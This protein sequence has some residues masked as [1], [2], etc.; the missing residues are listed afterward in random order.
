VLANALAVGAYFG[1]KTSFFA[2]AYGGT[3]WHNG[4]MRHFASMVGLGWWNAAIDTALTG[5]EHSCGWTFRLRDLSR[6][7]VPILALRADEFDRAYLRM[8]YVRSVIIRS[9]TDG[10]VPVFG[11]GE[12]R[13]EIRDEVEDERLAAGSDW[14]PF[15]SGLLSYA[16]WQ[17]WEW[18]K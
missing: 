18:Q 13:A 3:V 1:E 7:L 10:N 8:D 6:G 12:R 2:S 5:K 4:H 17:K 11:E 14:P 15:R 16:D 9:L